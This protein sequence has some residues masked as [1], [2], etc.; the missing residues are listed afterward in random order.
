MMDI[1]SR[2]AKIVILGGVPR[3]M[4]G[5]FDDI[6]LETESQ[7]VGDMRVDDGGNFVA[8]DC[9][10]GSDFMPGLS[11][12]PR[13]AE[14][15]TGFGSGKTTPTQRRMMKKYYKRNKKKELRERK[16]FRMKVKQE[17]RER[18]GG[19]SHKKRKQ[20]RNRD[21]PDAIVQPEKGNPREVKVLN[22]SQKKTL[23]A[24]ESH[25]EAPMRVRTIQ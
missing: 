20:Y 16:K 15:D 2:I 22:P 12:Y 18:P 21:Y 10:F 17:T 4:A 5:K 7:W 13:T 8:D 24:P 23:Q 19:R 14:E 9:E 25:V 6:T 3:R 1:I 11:G